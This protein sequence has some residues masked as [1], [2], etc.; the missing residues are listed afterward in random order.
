[1]RLRPIY[2][3]EADAWIRATHRHL[4]PPQGW[5]VGVA[6]E[7]DA[8]ELR[9]VGVLGRPLARRLQD[10]QTAEVTRVAVAEG[11]P[12][13][14]SMIYGALRRAAVALGYRRMVTYTLP[15]EG[16]ASLRASG[17]REDGRTDGGEWAREGRSSGPAL[18]PDQKTRW[19]WEVKP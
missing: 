2:R 6:L 10:G 7:D 13:G 3:R 1:M 19:I 17:W 16:G 12:N 8:G 9:G 15:S 18:L 11:V 5:I 14:C 4:P